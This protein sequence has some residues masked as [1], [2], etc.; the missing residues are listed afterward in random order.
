MFLL[1]AV[2]R[3]LTLTCEVNV[4]EV[5]AILFVVIH[6]EYAFYSQKKKDLMNTLQY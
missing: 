3:K 1:R 2:R 4:F 6:K 5:V